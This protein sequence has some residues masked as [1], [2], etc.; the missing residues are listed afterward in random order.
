MRSSWV[1][2]TRKAMLRN[3]V[4]EWNLDTM[5]PWNYVTN[6]A[7]IL[8]YWD[9]R[10]QT[11][12]AFENIYTVGMRGLSR[13]TARRRRHDGREGCAGRGHFRRPASDPGQSH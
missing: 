13:L 12:G 3:N 7:R 4:G 6:K 10:V 2:P 1:P 9:E 5:G 8:Q 11:N